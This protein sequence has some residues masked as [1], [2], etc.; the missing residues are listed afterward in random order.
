M[1]LVLNPGFESVDVSGDP[2]G[3]RATA[4]GGDLNIGGWIFEQ[5]GSDP[6]DEW[7]WSSMGTFWTLDAFGHPIIRIPFMGSQSGVVHSSSPLAP[8]GLIG[9]C[10]MI[11]GYGQFHQ[12]ITGPMST[13]KVK[14]R[15]TTSAT[16]TL[17]FYLDEVIIYSL[18]TSD[19]SFVNHES[20]T[21]SFPL[22]TH[23]FTVE[24][25]GPSDELVYIDDFTLSG[26]S[27]I[28]NSEI[29]MSGETLIPGIREK[30]EVENGI[31][32]EAG[33]RL[34]INNQSVL[35]TGTSIERSASTVSNPYIS[36]G[37]LGHQSGFQI[38]VI[39]TITVGEYNTSLES[40]SILLNGVLVIPELCGVM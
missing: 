19:S 29:S 33:C 2:G 3:Y 34:T 25:I 20:P 8:A 30:F 27:Y 16:F 9:Q 23:T 32:L 24:G 10:A 40:E 31:S 18:T 38:I 1:L 26:I 15:A 17:N 39:T 6:E 5:L 28:T 13:V 12:E 36:S 35:E 21:F 11:Q 37:A 22:G 7:T 4:S 14:F